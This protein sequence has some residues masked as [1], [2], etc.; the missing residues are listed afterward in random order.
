M[1]D[2]NEKFRDAL[3]RALGVLHLLD[4]GAEVREIH[5]D[6]GTVEIHLNAPPAHITSKCQLTLSNV[7]AH[8]G[9][10]LGVYVFWCEPAMT[11][12]AAA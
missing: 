1:N 11:E 2:T 4:D 8:T 10:L 3:N 12:V 7:T 5:I 6:A 9:V